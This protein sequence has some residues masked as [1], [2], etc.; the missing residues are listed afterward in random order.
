MP[1][2]NLNHLAP[3]ELQRHLAS[4][5]TIVACLCAAWCD[6]CRSY[7]ADFDA[8]SAQFPETLF[9]WIDIEDQSSL[10]DDLD[11]DNFPTL[12]IQQQDIVSFYGTMQPDTAQLRRLIQ[13]LTE[14]SPEQLRTLA[15]S[16]ALQRSWQLEANVRQ[17][18]AAH[19]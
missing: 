7:S 3:A 6:V 14:Q 2:F 1:S 13:S 19:V 8:L 18:I 11:I 10:V 4:H 12:L 9:L 17:R 5:G 16:G 15:N